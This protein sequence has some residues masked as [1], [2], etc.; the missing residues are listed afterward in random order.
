MSLIDEKARKEYQHQYYLN[1]IEKQRGIDTSEHKMSQALK[2]YH[3][4]RPE[5]LFKRREAILKKK[6]ETLTY[7]GN[8]YCACVKCG[9]TGIHALSIDHIEGNGAQHRK[10]GTIKG[11]FY[12][13]LSK[14]GYPKGYQTLCMNCQ[15]EKRYA[16]DIES[17][18]KYSS[19]II[20]L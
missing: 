2:R 6:I 10:E 7:Y 17:H 16:S 15:T 4:N 8:N 20:S 1:H 3:E 14:Q 18:R 19:G 11:R 9:Y 13:W 5:I 12:V